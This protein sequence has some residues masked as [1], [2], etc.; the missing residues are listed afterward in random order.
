[1]R[2]SKLKLNCRCYKFYSSFHPW[3]FFSLWYFD[4]AVKFCRIDLGLNKMLNWMLSPLR[5]ALFST[6]W[7]VATAPES[8]ARSASF[9]GPER[10][11]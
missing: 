5:I 7:Q 10:T 8:T 9:L 3:H 4:L 1:M 11:A 2:Q 6:E